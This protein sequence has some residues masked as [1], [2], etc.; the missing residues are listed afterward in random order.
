MQS[1]EGLFL[2]PPAK[3]MLE[4]DIKSKQYGAKYVAKNP[5]SAKFL[6]E[7]PFADVG[8]AE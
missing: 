4:N 1:I 6:F 2:N 5:R 8:D 3:E 7:L